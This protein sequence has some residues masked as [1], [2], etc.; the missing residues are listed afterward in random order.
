MV[1]GAWHLGR[2]SYA[3]SLLA[4]HDMTGSQLEVIA[5]I[6]TDT[7]GSTHAIVLMLQYARI[8]HG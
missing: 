3:D 2:C 6:A 5:R 8:V 1:G 7:H 4:M